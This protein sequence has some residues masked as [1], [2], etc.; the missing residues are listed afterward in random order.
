MGHSVAS[1]VLV[2]LVQLLGVLRLARALLVLPL[3]ATLLAHVRS[4]R[5]ALRLRA[6]F[7]SVLVPSAA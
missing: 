6:V 3:L 4:M 5:L 7:S 2:L 1:E